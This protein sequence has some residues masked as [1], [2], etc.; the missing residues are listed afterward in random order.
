MG[1]TFDEEYVRYTIPLLI[2]LGFTMR[3]SE[4]AKRQMRRASRSRAHT[5]FLKNGDFAWEVCNN[6]QDGDVER[7]C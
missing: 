1:A 4:A 3:V 5:G 7:T 6:W 2:Y